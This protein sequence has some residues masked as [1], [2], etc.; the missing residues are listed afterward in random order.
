MSALATSWG[1]R[2]SP[3]E[4]W[5]RYLQTAISTIRSPSP[6]LCCQSDGLCRAFAPCSTSLRRNYQSR[7]GSPL[8]AGRR[9][10]E[11]SVFA[12]P[13]AAFDDADLVGQLSSTICGACD[14][15]TSATRSISTMSWADSREDD[16]I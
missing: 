9:E 8:F 11:L 2:R 5:S 13:K 16:D 3:M 1:M 10:L 14:R 4:R 15:Y 7:D 6:H 12:P